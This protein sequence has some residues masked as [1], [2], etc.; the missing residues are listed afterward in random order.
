MNDGFFWLSILVACGIGSLFAWLLQH[1]RQR[2][3]QQQLSDA[4][5]RAAMDRENIEQLH[6]ELRTLREQHA[7]TREA[8]AALQVEKG[9]LARQIE[10]RRNRLEEAMRVMQK[11]FRNISSALFDETSRR[12]QEQSGKNLQLLLT[13]LREHLHGFQKKME[14]AFVKQGKEQFSLTAQIERIVQVNQTLG[15]Q[16]DN[17][18][19]ALKSDVQVQGGWGEVMLE[20]IVQAAGLRQGE[21]YT[22]QGKDLKLKDEGGRHLK[23]DLI[24]HLP[25][26]RSIVIDAKVSMLSY[27]QYINADNDS[28][29]DTGLKHFAA[30]MQNHVNGLAERGYHT[31]ANLNSPDFTLLFTPI[32]GAFT[33]LTQ[34]CRTI[35]ENAWEKRIAI[36]SPATLWPVLMTVQSLWRLERQNR[37]ADEIAVEGGRL[38]DKV[39]GFVSDME[40][41]G[42]Q[43]DSVRNTCSEAFN[44]LRSGRGNILQRCEK[45]K[46]LGARTR[47]TLP[48]ESH[49]PGS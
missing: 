8:H 20:R 28:D 3:Q 40:K 33:L 36:V 21:E 37:H 42:R 5:A 47:K 12:F 7:Q 41:L 31:T 11:E 27:E 49:D 39:A 26:E 38:Y 19:N 46:E 15:Q 23:P 24:V 14:E 45:L 35:Q 34:R 29:R 48:G 17:L 43:I 22:V 30:S 44:K 25:D 18:V 10:E 4:A 13:P 32:E 16:T 2:R 9:I 1:R 6:T